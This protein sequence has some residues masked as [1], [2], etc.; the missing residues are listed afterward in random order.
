MIESQH[1]R[2]FRPSLKQVVIGSLGSVIGLIGIVCAVALY[3]VEVI[4]HPKKQEVRDLY[5]FT[6]FELGL[7]AEAVVFPPLHG[8]YHVSGWFIPSPQ[9]TTTILVCPGYRTGMSD[10]LGMS[11]HLWRAGHNVLV[12]EYYGHGTEVGKPVTLGY[13]EI[14]DFLGAIAYAKQRG[15]HTRLGVIA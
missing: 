14:N 13:R 4:I 12:F 9:A 5:T 2:Q 1:V 3:V 11:A 7:P 8:D 15:P 10:T 6:P